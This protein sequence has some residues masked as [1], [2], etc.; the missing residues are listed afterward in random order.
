MTPSVG[1]AS[2][3]HRPDGHGGPMARMA[4]LGLGRA[5]RGRPCLGTGQSRGKA[6]G[7]PARVARAVTA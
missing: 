1:P 5:E 2:G 7:G 3:G 6:A 4:E